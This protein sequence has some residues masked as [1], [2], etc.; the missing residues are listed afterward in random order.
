[1]CVY[2]D[3]YSFDPNRAR[4][5]R[6]SAV[7]VYYEGYGHECQEKSDFL[8]SINVEHPFWKDEPLD[9]LPLAVISVG[10]T[11]GV[12]PST[13]QFCEEGRYRGPEGDSDHKID[14]ADRDNRV[15]TNFS[16]MLV[17]YVEK[18][19]SEELKVGF[20]Y[21]G[22]LGRKWMDNP[23]MRE[24]F[25]KKFQEIDLALGLDE[26]KKISLPDQSVKNYPKSH[27]KGVRMAFLTRPIIPVCST[28]LR[29]S[30]IPFVP[31]SVEERFPALMRCGPPKIF[32]VYRVNTTNTPSGNPPPRRPSA[33]SK[34]S[35]QHLT[36]EQKKE[37]ERD[38]VDLSRKLDLICNLR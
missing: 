30:A 2:S 13:V 23:I 28:Y 25:G 14:S 18:A 9:V 4:W 1:M 31:G 35:T 33:S 15:S 8:E 37:Q 32:G 22:G 36:W 24:G 5:D 27:Y 16:Q 38:Y 20:F 10:S 7:W 29:A 6:E 34:N 12:D 3:I 26:T 17:D 11:H 19:V 21:I